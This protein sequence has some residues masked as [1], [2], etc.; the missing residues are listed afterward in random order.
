MVKHNS[1]YFS[2]AVKVCR[3]YQKDYDKFVATSLE[4]RGI[5]IK[6]TDIPI[7][8]SFAAAFEGERIRKNDMFAEFGGNKMTCDDLE[9]ALS[10]VGAVETTMKSDPRERNRPKFSGGMFSRE[11]YSSED[12]DSDD[13]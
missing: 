13:Y 4:A 1:K 8:V 3:K 6:V 5:K 2:D 12:D 7:P 10:R 11:R 9:W